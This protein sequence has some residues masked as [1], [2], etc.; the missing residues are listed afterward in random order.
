MK[1]KMMGGRKE[2]RRRRKTRRRRRRRGNWEEGDLQ[3]MT[4][5]PTAGGRNAREGNN[6][7]QL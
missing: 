5:G 7:L 3:S 4:A 1:G 6:L 2:C